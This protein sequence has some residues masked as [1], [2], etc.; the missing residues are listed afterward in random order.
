MKSQSLTPSNHLPSQDR[1]SWFCN[2][3]DVT[4]E[5]TSVS[6][7]FETLKYKPSTDDSSEI[8]LH[9]P[10][11]YLFQFW[12][13][14]L[15]L[16]SLKE[17]CIWDK[18]RICNRGSVQIHFDLGGRF[19]LFILTFL[20]LCKVTEYEVSLLHVQIS[21]SEQRRVRE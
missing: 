4:P 15:Y 20:I 1:F 18:Y 14:K 6:V 12:K 8:L 9:I 17:L 11:E 21:L 13:S 10:H 7:Q 3:S 2:H 16:F 5:L 19:Y